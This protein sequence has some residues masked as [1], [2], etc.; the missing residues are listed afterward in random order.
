MK[1]FLSWSGERASV[2]A[3]ALSKW[4]P[5]VLQYA[6]PW[7]S[8]DHIRAGA[9]W[10]VE[11]GNALEACQFG[12]IVLTPENLTEPWIL[13]EA[14][15]LSRVYSSG[16]VCPWLV[17]LDFHQVALP[18]AQFQA[19]KATAEST[20]DLVHAINARAQAPLDAGRLN[21]VLDW[22]MPQLEEQLAAVLQTASVPARPRPSNDELLDELVTLARSMDDRLARMHLAQDT[23]DRRDSF[24]GLNGPRPAYA[25]ISVVIH[26]GFPFL[27]MRGLDRFGAPAGEGLMPRIARYC[28]LDPEGYGASWFLFDVTRRETLSRAGAE[29]FGMIAANSDALAQKGLLLT[30]HHIEPGTDPTELGGQSSTVESNNSSNDPDVDVP[31]GVPSE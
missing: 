27:A 6:E 11:L 7:L 28:G 3:S 10:T 2:A 25:V 19:T 30:R 29:A 18:L 12:I 13:F 23:I 21:N 8:R 31:P 4:L 16:A 9:R 24:V 26:G 14:G 22:A 1:I 5:H 17:D 15:A 20:R